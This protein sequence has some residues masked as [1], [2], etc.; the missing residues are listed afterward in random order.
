MTDDEIL[1]ALDEPSDIPSLLTHPLTAADVARRALSDLRSGNAES[2]AAFVLL[3]AVER[4]ELVRCPTGRTGRPA[5][6]GFAMRM[7]IVEHR[8]REAGE[9]NPTKRIAEALQRAGRKPETEGGVRK[10]IS[11]FLNVP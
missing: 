9:A 6:N 4:G 7:C 1:T 10:R 11:R 2:V 8:L 5:D 3:R